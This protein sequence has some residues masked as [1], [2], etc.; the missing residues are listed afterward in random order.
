MI[1]SLLSVMGLVLIIILVAVALVI[2]V[3]VWAFR[4]RKYRSGGPFS[5]PPPPA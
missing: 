2:G 5:P 1:A 3:I 4:G